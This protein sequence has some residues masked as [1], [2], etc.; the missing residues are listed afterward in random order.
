M[1]TSKLNK[2][3]RKGDRKERKDLGGG[4]WSC[5]HTPW[6]PSSSPGG[7]GDWIQAT[8]LNSIFGRDPGVHCLSSEKLKVLTVS[9]VALPGPLESLGFSGGAC[10]GLGRDH[11]LGVR[12]GQVGAKKC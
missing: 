10:E 6:L 11:Q 9:S 1:D 8:A 7:F 3:I 5:E 12:M 4:I 2:H